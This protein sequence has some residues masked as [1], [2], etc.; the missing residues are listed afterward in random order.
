MTTEIEQFSELIDKSEQLVFLSGA[1]ISTESG[2]P[3]FRS[4]DGL[5]SNPDNVNIFDI[6]AFL[7]DPSP[8]YR[9]SQKFLPIMEKASP[10]RAPSAIA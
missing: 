9:F 3:D 6:S 4:A 5:Y 2:I 7:A 8:F 10:T 1:G